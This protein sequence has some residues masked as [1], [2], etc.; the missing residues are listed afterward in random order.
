MADSGV[1]VTFNAADWSRLR[2]VAKINGCSVA[3]MIHSWVLLDLCDAETLPA[4]V[5]ATGPYED[6]SKLLPGE[7][8]WRT[9]DGAY[10]RGTVRHG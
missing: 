3:S 1:R 10:V 9:G 5:V 4:D 2:K 7:Y 8:T 6:G